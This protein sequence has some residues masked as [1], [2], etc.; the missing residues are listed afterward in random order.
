M[1]RIP[2]GRYQFGTESDSKWFGERRCQLRL[3]RPFREWLVP[4]LTHRGS[5]SCQRLP[6]ALGDVVQLFWS[7]IVSRLRDEDER[8]GVGRFDPLSPRV[9]RV[10]PGADSPN[11]PCLVD[12]HEQF[13]WDS[14]RALNDRQLWCLR[15]Q[16][17]QSD[18]LIKQLGV[19]EM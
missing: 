19:G 6:V 15:F 17:I 16:L 8:R 13:G 2:R 14:S 11:L 18:R 12:P 9:C 1:C 10:P 7:P 3:F 4:S 5:P